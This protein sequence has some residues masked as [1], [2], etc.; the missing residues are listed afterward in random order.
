MAEGESLLEVHNCS[1]C[2][3]LTVEHWRLLDLRSPLMVEAF[4]VMDLAREENVELHV[5]CPSER[6][7]QSYRR[8][9]K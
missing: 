7:R 3:R 4:I 6:G 8:G 1:A 2:R 9:L 5:A